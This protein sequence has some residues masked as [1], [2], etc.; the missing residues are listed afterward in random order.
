M[1]VSLL[2]PSGWPNIAHE[3]NSENFIDHKLLDSEGILKKYQT[4]IFAKKWVWSSHA[5]QG[6]QTFLGIFFY[7]YLDNKLH[8]TS[9]IL[10]LN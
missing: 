9:G 5:L 10:I 6:G 2:R 1:G 4:L 7:F 3:N 8:D